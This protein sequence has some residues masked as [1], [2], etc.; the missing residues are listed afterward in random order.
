MFNKKLL[1]PGEAMDNEIA[2]ISEERDGFA[3]LGAN[4][5][6]DCISEHLEDAPSSTPNSIPKT[7]AHLYYMESQVRNNNEDGNLRRWEGILAI[8]GLSRIYGFNITMKPAF[9]EIS[10]VVKNILEEDLKEELRVKDLKSEVAVIEKDNIP[11]AIT[12]KEVLICPFCEIDPSAF[13][14]VPWFKNGVWEKPEK[15]LESPEKNKLRAW[16]QRL[17]LNLEAMNNFIGRLRVEG[18]G[19]NIGVTAAIRYEGSTSANNA[20]SFDNVKLSTNNNDDFINVPRLPIDMPEIFND[21]L[22][23][24]AISKEA[25]LGN[26]FCLSFQCDDQQEPEY[27]GVLIPFTKAFIQLMEEKRNVVDQGQEL[28]VRRVSVKKEDESS[29]IIVTVDL[30]NGGIPLKRYKEY[31]KEN[32]RLIQDF[33][34]ITLWPYVDLPQNRWN[35][36]IIAIRQKAKRNVRTKFV[37]GMNKIEGNSVKIDPQIGGN[38][39]FNCKVEAIDSKNYS[40]YINRM[41]KMPWAI[42]FEANEFGNKINLGAI[43]IAKSSV[44]CRDGNFTKNVTIALDFG[45]TNTLC[46]IYDGVTE[47]LRLNALEYSLDITECGKEEKAVFEQKYWMEKKILE[48]KI[49]SI[50]QLYAGNGMQSIPYQDGRLFINDVKTLIDFCQD[51]NSQDNNS[52]DLQNKGIFN[53]LKFYGVSNP[54]VISATKIFLKTILAFAVLQAKINGANLFQINVSYPREEV[55]QA[56]QGYEPEIIRY[57][58]TRCCCGVNN[59]IYNTEAEAA[60]LYFQT[61]PLA[62]VPD[63]QAGY[64]IIDIGGGTSDISL[65]KN[66]ESGEIEN[67]GVVSL[68]YAG[69]RIIIRSIYETFKAFPDQ[70]SHIW[71]S[72]RMNNTI[73]QEQIKDLK[74]QLQNWHRQIRREG[75]RIEDFSPASYNSICNLIETLIEKVGLNTAIFNNINTNIES[76]QSLLVGMIRIKFT[77]LFYILANF[78]KETNAIN[79][80]TGGIFKIYLAGGATKALR[81]CN[82]GQDV[83]K[84]QITSYRNGFGCYLIQMVTKILG[85][86]EDD[87]SIIFPMSGMEKKEVVLGLAITNQDKEQIEV[88]SH[89]I[90]PLTWSIDLNQAQALDQVLQKRYEDYVNTYLLNINQ[91]RN[92]DVNQMLIKNL[93]MR[94]S[95]ENP[96]VR[97]NYRLLK[98]GIYDIVYNETSQYPDLLKKDIFVAFMVENLLNMSLVDNIGE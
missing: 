48:E 52:Q 62:Q 21:T 72:E 63:P 29:K 27:Y 5:A 57:L 66:N 16:L 87:V 53:N 36:Y 19:S 76:F 40:W 67:K 28:V 32:I 23:I 75:N 94:I 59:F 80:E 64:A 91:N 7:T 22:A 14:D 77:N 97:N 55:K 86:K 49:P 95:L 88:A 3:R 17:N 35:E 81:F 82:D 38:G 54:N 78:I 24:V 41:N 60:A 9:T 46:E 20:Y 30:S 31:Y 70:F 85:V 51:K 8:I 93:K 25:R 96:T 37:Q 6:L 98:Q 11:I 68:L 56:F 71:N 61:R 69:R 4:E 33:P 42:N 10:S 50:S 65:W 34:Y 74:G 26:E 47:Q 79:T 73:T 1:L 13:H 58:Q 43:F 83:S 15:C 90:T 39:I 44:G 45:T 12:H 84:G 92:K 2:R 18:I 89:K